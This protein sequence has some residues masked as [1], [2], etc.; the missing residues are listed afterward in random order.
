MLICVSS[1]IHEFLPNNILCSSI[2]WSMAA[3]KNEKYIETT[4]VSSTFL[5]PK[6]L[7]C[8]VDILFCYRELNARKVIILAIYNSNEPTFSLSD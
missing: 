6:I 7:V 1:E 3:G 5:L 4:V 8:R 2:C